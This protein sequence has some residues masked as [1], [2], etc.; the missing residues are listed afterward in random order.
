MT[1]RPPSPAASL[2][3]LP[4]LVLAACTA[5]GS[6]TVGDDDADPSGGDDDGHAGEVAPS[7]PPQPP[8]AGFAEVRVDPVADPVLSP[9]ATVGVLAAVAQ[10]SRAD[11]W[12]ARIL[13]GDGASVAISPRAPLPPGGI[14]EARWDLAG[15]DGEPVAPG[16]YT[17]ETRLWRGAERVASWSA[18][19][20]SVRLGPV[21]VALRAAGD[22]G[23][24]EVPLLYHRTGGVRRNYYTIPEEQAEWSLPAPGPGESDLDAAPGQPR[25]APEPWTD[26]ESPPVDGDGVPLAT[27]ASLP[28]AFV[29][30]SRVVAEVV[31][32][33]TA[34]HGEEVVPAGVPA[35]GLPLRVVATGF[36]PSEPVGEGSP[37][38]LESLASPAPLVGRYPQDLALRFEWLGEDGTWHPVPGQAEVALVVYGT[39]GPS[40]AGDG[41]AAPGPYDA[42]V[43]VV[44]EVAGWVGGATADP[45]EV[46]A[47]VQRGVLYDSGLVYDTRS[48]ASSYTSYSGGD[49]ERSRFDLGDYLRRADGEVVNCSDCASIVATYANMMGC[50]LEYLIVGWDFDL[51]FIRAVGVE[52]FTEFPFGAP[53]GGGFS[54]HAVTSPDSGGTI[55]D[56]TLAIDGDADPMSAPSVETP[57]DGVD[58]EWYLWALSSEW[59]SIGYV[60]EARTSID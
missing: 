24:M 3:A 57:P 36:S 56:G 9:G 42:W 52:D 47:L 11:A 14:V 29:A 20:R 46:A 5:P 40:T 15:P 59:D 27:G 7:P 17:L 51:N 60:Y 35:D 33:A 58:G 31:L 12:D 32:G 22:G 13:L 45:T 23:A 55:Y 8:G 48:G 43:Q 28:A 49:W 21:S 1:L 19:V 30:G 6:G 38:V 44:D 16:T 39:A 53:Y 18:Q 34:L 54:Y 25:T 41:A 4:W 2:L 50:D 26:L 37:A 10:G